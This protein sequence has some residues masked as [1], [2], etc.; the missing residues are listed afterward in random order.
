LHVGNAGCF[1]VKYRKTDIFVVRINEKTLMFQLFI[2]ILGIEM[3]NKY[4]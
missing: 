3:K 2:V 1:S 4:T